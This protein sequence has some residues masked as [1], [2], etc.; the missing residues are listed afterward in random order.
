MTIYDL[1]YFIGYSV[2]FLMILSAIVVES[3]KQQ[4]DIP[5]SAVFIFSLLCGFLSWGL[6]IFWIC[7]IIYERKF[8][9]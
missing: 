8:K 9:R 6:P 7:K 3:H 5:F 1:I 2:A 4:E